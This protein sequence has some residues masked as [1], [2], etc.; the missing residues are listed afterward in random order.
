MIALIQR[1]KIMIFFVWLF[2]LSVFTSC[3]NS[4]LAVYT[5]YLS[6]ENLASYHVGTPDP[7]LNNPTI[8]QRLIVIWTLKKR[9]L[10]Y[11][12]L[13]LKISIRFRNKKEAAIKV[14]LCKPKG[15]YVYALLNEDYIATDGILTYKV[16]L[17]GDG[18]IL[19]EWRHQ[20]WTNLILVGQKENCNIDPEKTDL[21]RTE[22]TDFENF[23]DIDFS[24]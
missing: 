10:H 21:E 1:P 22:H 7:Y 20:I 4:H 5:D 12:D 24:E 11:E 15:T 2:G 13:H 18:C 14:P 16:E 8:G 3:T 17:I 6:H 23:D 19:D 9:H